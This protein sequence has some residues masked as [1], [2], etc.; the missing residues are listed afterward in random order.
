MFIQ[1]IS[2]FSIVTAL[3]AASLMLIT[4]AT[5][6]F[7]NP[8]R[9]ASR[10]SFSHVDRTAK[11]DRLMRV[12]QG[13]GSANP[14]AIELSGPSDLV[15]RDRRGNIVFAVDHSARTTTVGK[16]GG[17]RLT[18]PE[19]P[20]EAHKPLPD[21]CEGAFSPYVEPSK[22]HILG[23]CLSFNLESGWAFS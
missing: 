15:I 7:S 3:C 5:S 14:I 13:Q 18:S 1:R 21:G 9:R 20:G 22:A 11:S 23:R 6:A 10:G 19:T 4:Q 12:R 2:R 16:Q 8:S 17:G